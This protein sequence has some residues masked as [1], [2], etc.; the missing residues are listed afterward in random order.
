MAWN[1]EARHRPSADQGK[2]LPQKKGYMEALTMS[3]M[4]RVMEST[5]ILPQLW[6]DDRVDEEAREADAHRVDNGQHGQ[7]GA[8]VHGER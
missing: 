8:P 5:T 1:G 6:P 4:T 2:N 7:L 3:Q